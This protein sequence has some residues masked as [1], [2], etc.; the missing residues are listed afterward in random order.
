MTDDVDAAGE[1]AAPFDRLDS[2]AILLADH[3]EGDRPVLVYRV[4]SPEASVER[5]EAAGWQRPRR[6]EIPPG[7]CV[8]FATPGGHRFA[9]YEPTRPEVADHFAGGADF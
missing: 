2:P 7:P 8:S 6:L 5:I 4:P 9:L 1:P 3:V